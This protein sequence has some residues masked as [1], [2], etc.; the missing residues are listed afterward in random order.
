MGDRAR[1][2]WMRV[3]L[4]ASLAAGWLT[5]FGIYGSSAAG[6]GSLA[7]Q[8]VEGIVLALAL[9]G[10][11]GVVAWIVAPRHRRLWTGALAGLLMAGSYAIGY[12][13]IANLWVDAAQRPWTDGAALTLPELSFW[14]G[15]AIDVAT[16]LCLG[17]MGWAVAEIAG[18]PRNTMTA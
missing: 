8:P 6:S 9:S 1:L 11:A 18:R 4:L 16:S 12:V 13:L 7:G 14:V 5:W 17:V 10:W 15:F 2:N 3:G